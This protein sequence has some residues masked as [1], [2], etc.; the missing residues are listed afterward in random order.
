MAADRAD[1][2]FRCYPK[3]E[4]DD[5]EVFAAAASALLAHYPDDVIEAVTDPATGIPAHQ[6]WC[7]RL[8]EIREACEAIMVPRRRA[9]EHARELARTQAVM[10]G[11]ETARA[12]RPSYEDLKAKYGEGWGI[13][14]KDNIE[15]KN[16]QMQH[17]LDA[18][19]A[20]FEREC[21]QAGMDPTGWYSPTL[22]A[23]ELVQSS[24]TRYADI[25]NRE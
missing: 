17:I 4:A 12:Q 7:P 25:P 16:E 18:N 1:L 19:K 14:Q 22:A 10:R 8:S 13:S 5:P 21:R 15:R 6:K 24:A 20:T 9:E 11:A 2:L 23:S 3:S